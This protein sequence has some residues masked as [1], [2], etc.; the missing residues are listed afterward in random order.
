MQS[1]HN[2]LLC[3]GLFGNPHSRNPT[4]QATTRLVE[5]ARA[6]VL[7]FFH[8]SADEYVAIF[9]ANASTALKL[10]GESYPF[11]TGDHYLLTF[12]NHNSVNGIREYARARQ[13]EISYVPVNLPEM[14]VEEAVLERQWTLPRAGGHNLFAYPAQSIF[15]RAAPA[16]VDRPRSG[17]G[18]GCTAG[19]RCVCGNQPA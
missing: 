5:R 17:S 10:V 7:E 6:K 19:R 15:R 2:S 14:R 13:A 8:A 11:A 1:E 3:E 4:S 9:T 16:G 12:D 18:L